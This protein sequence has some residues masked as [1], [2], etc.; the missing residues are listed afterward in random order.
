MKVAYLHVLPL[1]YYPPAR[2]TLKLIAAREGWRVRAWTSRNRRRLPD[3][4][5]P[6]VVVARFRDAGASQPLPFRIGAYLAWH[7]R[8]AFEIAAWHPDAL[9]SVE[10]HSALA[11]WLYYH[12]FHGNAPLFIH[13]HEYYSAADFLAE[14]M[15]TLRSTAR[16]ERD[17]LFPRA[18]WVSET[19]SERLSLLRAWTPQIRQ[20]TARVLP[21]YPPQKW[22]E[23][24]ARLERRPLDNQTR[25]VCVGSVSFEDT[26]IREAATWVAD[27]PEQASLHVVSDNMRVD[28]QSWLRSLNAP[29]VTF[30]AHGCD[31]EELPQLLTQFDAG[32]V[33]YKGNTLNFVHN[34]PNKA[35]EYLACGLEVWYPPE[36]IGMQNFQRAHPELRIVQINF[37]DPPGRLPLVGPRSHPTREF[38]FTCE[39]ALAPLF[40][41]I[42]AAASSARR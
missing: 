11:A 22:I 7:A 16:L 35:I 9:I 40:A 26:F 38:P 3:W 12:V 28:V 42:E 36:M 34:V 31:Y 17:D 23:T 14:G 30:D 8:A 13:H 41:E 1:E 4:N 29:N 33:L 37:R 20:E 27:R 6:N 15:R 10:P 21:N 25:L 5:E 18:R 2:N 24:A 32:L 39:T 19:N